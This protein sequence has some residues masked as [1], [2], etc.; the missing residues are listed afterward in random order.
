MI[1]ASDCIDL[2]ARENSFS[3]SDSLFIMPLIPFMAT[4]C[5]AM[6]LMFL[7]ALYKLVEDVII[8]DHVIM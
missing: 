2:Q 7:Y 5:M 8:T 3:L 4:V 6:R 1:L